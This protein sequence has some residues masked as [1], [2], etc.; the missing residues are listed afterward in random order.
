MT[1]CQVEQNQENVESSGVIATRECAK[2]KKETASD[3][4][5]AGSKVE[6]SCLRTN[7]EMTKARQLIEDLSKEFDGIVKI[8]EKTGDYRLESNE[9]VYNYPNTTF[10]VDQA[11]V[12]AYDPD[13]QSF[14]IRN[15]NVGGKSVFS[16]VEYKD[17]LTTQVEYLQ[18]KET[19]VSLSSSMQGVNCTDKKVTIEFTK[20]PKPC[21]EVQDVVNNYNMLMV[22]PGMDNNECCFQN[23]VTPQRHP[24]QNVVRYENGCYRGHMICDKRRV[25]YNF[26]EREFKP[27]LE[28]CGGRL[29]LTALT[30]NQFAVCTDL[31]KPMCDFR[32][33]Y[34][35]YVTQSPMNGWDLNA[36]QY[37]LCNTYEPTQYNSQRHEY[38]CMSFHDDV[39]PIA[40]YDTTTDT[41]QVIIGGE[42][43]HFREPEMVEFLTEYNADCLD[44][45]KDCE[46]DRGSRYVKQY[47]DK[48]Y[49]NKAY[50]KFIKAEQKQQKADSAYKEEYDDLNVDHQ[51]LIDKYDNLL[52]AC[53]NTTDKDVIK[54]KGKIEKNEQKM[55]KKLAKA[56]KKYNKKMERVKKYRAKACDIADKGLEDRKD[57]RADDQEAFQKDLDKKQGVK[58]KKKKNKKDED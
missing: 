23:V 32:D 55:I 8:T 46:V 40:Q 28:S 9:F 11:M 35:Q 16:S 43:C 53:K 18:S 17:L 6:Q 14:T 54:A 38:E 49:E 33:Q 57:D 39:F 21:K 47:V 12:V 3:I 15:G 51:S 41:H 31:P 36:N 42:T 22:L 34:P 7:V 20:K 37:A 2:A 48:K 1:V 58:R 56:K 52:A 13:F 29:D 26:P 4:N 30:H 24:S 44:D 27:F 10:E 19:N 45:I 25:D 50:K 5:S